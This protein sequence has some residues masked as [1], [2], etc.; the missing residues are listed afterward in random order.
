MGWEQ[1]GGQGS[2]DG[3]LPY[4]VR[5]K[6]QGRMRVTEQTLAQIF[7]LKHL[8]WFALYSHLPPTPL[9]RLNSSVKFPLL[10]VSWA[11]VCKK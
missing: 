11:G 10:G 4:G 1:S 3:W 6:P 9:P 7:Y 2:A 8:K 5:D